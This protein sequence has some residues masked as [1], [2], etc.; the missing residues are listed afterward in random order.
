MATKEQINELY[1]KFGEKKESA[2]RKS[3][4][5]LSA[6]VKNTGIFLCTVIVVPFLLLFVLYKA[7]CDDNKQISIRKFFN[8]KNQKLTTNVG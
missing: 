6:I 2:K 8:F 4:L 1:K 7:F 3:S 5:N